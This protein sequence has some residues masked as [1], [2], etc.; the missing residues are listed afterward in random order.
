M[1]ENMKVEF[2]RTSDID[3]WMQ[4]VRKVSW[5][6]PG[7]ETEQSIEEHKIIVLKFMNDKRALCVKNEEDIVGV[8][9]YSRKHNMICCLAVDPAYRKKGIASMLLS[10]ALDKLDRDKDI[11]VST[12][13]END[14]KG[15]APRNLYKKFGFEEDELIEEF[16]YPNQR[17]VLHANI[18]ANNVP[19]VVVRESK[20]EDLTEILHLCLYLH[21]KSVPEESE[22]LRSTWENIMNDNNHHLIVCE[23]DGKIVASCVCVVITNLTRNVRPY[24]FVE[25]VVTHADYRKKGYA[26]DCLN[27]AKHIAKEN[28]CYK[29]MLLTG[30]K[31]ESTLNFYRNAGYNSTDKTAFIQWIDM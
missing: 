10:E 15:I 30:S 1:I 26:T 7:L 9:L 16:G 27:Y 14:V 21:E 17:F 25:N 19:I 31:E 24:A 20:E 6:F 2:G 12:F 13:R 23:V 29:M 22:Q 3:S 28:N 5:N 8:L 4:L 18:G 11:T